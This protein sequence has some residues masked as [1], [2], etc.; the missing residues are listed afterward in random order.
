MHLQLFA[1]P[2]SFRSSLAITALL[3]IVLDY[4]RVLTRSISAKKKP[5]E[6]IKV[7]EIEHRPVL[8]IPDPSGIPT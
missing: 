2:L 6:Y 5:S 8:H 1:T 3:L 7:I 4:R